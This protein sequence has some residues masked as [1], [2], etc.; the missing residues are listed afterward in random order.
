[1]MAD[2]Q[3]VALRRP[4]LRTIPPF[5]NSLIRRSLET[6]GPP[7]LIREGGEHARFLPFEF[8]EGG[9][10]HIELRQ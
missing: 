10:G 5:Q 6:R 8:M 7:S 1:M 4:L 2:I 3:D 9:L